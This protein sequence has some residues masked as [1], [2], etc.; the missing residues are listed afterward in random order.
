[1]VL[2]NSRAVVEAVKLA[3]TAHPPAPPNW[4]RWPQS[5]Y[6]VMD[7]GML[8]YDRTAAPMARPLV[9]PQY[10]PTPS[11][12]TSMS[13]IPAAQ[14]Q[15]PMN[16]DSF[17][18]YS[19]ATS[20]VASP[21]RHHFS[22]RAPVRVVTEADMSHARGFRREAS[23]RIEPSRS[24]S[25]K[26]EAQMSVARSVSSSQSVPPRTITSIVPVNPANQVSFNTEVDNLVKA[27]QAKKDTDGIVKKV[28][29]EQ[30]SLADIPMVE[31][32][33]RSVSV[34]SPAAQADSP[35]AEGR[36]SRKRYEC[37]IAGCGKT[38]FQKTHLDIHKRSHT[39]DK[40]Y[41]G[42]LARASSRR[43]H[44]DLLA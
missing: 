30:Q 38:F 27:L 44:A 26:S 16:F 31:P 8:P 22:E 43:Y 14:Y 5:D 36:F 19:P 23:T 21:Y 11:Y 41:V 40:P 34:K 20:A 10:F 42:N 7:S 3:L 24:P 39:G 28:E 4:G 12:T 33:A 25:I 6:M 15:T 37:D 9:A 29:A 17:A 1:V 35:Q 2:L 18:S 13:S 32:I